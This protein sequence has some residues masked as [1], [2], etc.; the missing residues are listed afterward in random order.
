MAKK[1]KCSD[2]EAAIAELAL[3]LA[4]LPENRDLDAVVASMKTLVD[5][6][7]NR[8]LV[9]DAVDKFTKAEKAKNED[10]I[11][12]QLEKFKQ[13]VK[14]DKAL[15]FAIDNLQGQLET[16]FFQGS[17]PRDAVS[18]ASDAIK[19]LRK[20]RNKLTTEKRL[21]ERKTVVEKQI[22]EGKI[23]PAKPK[24]VIDKGDPFDRLRA[25]LKE[26]NAQM[27]QHREIKD[28]E[29]QLKTLVF[30]TP[31]AKKAEAITEARK[32]NQARLDALRFEVKQKMEELRP[33][34]KLE[35]T[36]DVLGVPRAIMS[37]TDLS[38]LGLQGWFN[39]VGH[40][41][42]ASEQLANSVRAMFN[43]TKAINIQN[44]IT[45]DP[46]YEMYKDAGGYIAP[47]EGGSLN[48]R[49]EVFQ[50]NLAEKIPVL[51]PLIKASSRGYVTFLNGLRFQVWKQM[52]RSVPFD[53]AAT[54]A[55]QFAKFTNIATGRGTLGKKGD[56]SVPYLN[57]LFFSVRNWA[58]RLQLLAGNPLWGGDNQTR[59]V[60]AK[61][62]AKFLG[63]TA[64]LMLLGKLIGGELE[65]DPRGGGF[66]KL[67]FGDTTVDL[68]AQ[69]GAEFSFL[70]KLITKQMKT[71]KGEIIPLVDYS[72]GKDDRG[73][74][75][76][77]EKFRAKLSPMASYAADYLTGKTF[78][79]RPFNPVSGA[80]ER[81]I[82]LSAQE[83]Y[84]HFTT[85]NVPSASL[86]TALS[87]FGF[88]PSTFNPE[89]HKK[90]MDAIRKAYKESQNR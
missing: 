25:E 73:Q 59:K 28:L 84:E 76:I 57:M 49:E 48:S 37:S 8:T 18:L 72:F 88:R 58:S 45:S 19:A 67:R 10:A 21:S 56:L 33:K 26:I 54:A 66:G 89:A 77:S 47:V 5:P 86:L 3:D 51:G 23:E 34:T 78:D 6:S 24:E 14:D 46:M 40:P 17:A 29:N 69:L 53:D 32:R 55:K 31:K 12:Q 44:E 62:Y 35:K 52:M 85:Q 83:V 75:I 61:E 90:K 68:T 74:R 87:F 43:R 39:S 41:L 79:D 80:A 50:S 4:T 13:E 20:K 1:V 15:T 70:S 60:I 36:M 81:M 27:R 16:G 11:K 7:L 42:V 38:A 30:K 65:P 2:L 9:V 82:P 64:L 71:R 63:G 22:S